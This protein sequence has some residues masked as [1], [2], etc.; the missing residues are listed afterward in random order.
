MGIISLCKDLE[1]NLVITS[2][3]IE[4]CYTLKTICLFRSISKN[5][6]GQ[7]FVFLFAL[8]KKVFYLTFL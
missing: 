7:A 6:M 3:L 2:I 5:F 1:R 8:K 4:K